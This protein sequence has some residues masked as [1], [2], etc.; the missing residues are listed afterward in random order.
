MVSPAGL[1]N[2]PCQR[3]MSRRTRT[4]L[5]VAASLLYPEVSEGV[6][7]RLQRKRQKAKS[8]FDRSGKLLPDLDVGQEVR[9]RGQR[10]KTW[11]LGKCLEKLSD[12]S[13]M[14]QTNGEKIRRDR[15]VQIIQKQK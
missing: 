10:D 5:P 4:L 7:E 13:F 11:K 9:V 8:N 6:K 1:Q 3:L 12:R 14:V 15:I 2:S